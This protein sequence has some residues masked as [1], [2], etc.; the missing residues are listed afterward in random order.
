MWR[1]GE[2]KKPRNRKKQSEWERSKKMFFYLK[3]GDDQS[4]LFNSKCHLVVLLNFIR[5]QLQLPAHLTLDFMPLSNDVKQLIPLQLP[6][7]GDTTYANTLLGPRASYAL[8]SVTEDEDGAKEYTL[9]WKS[10]STRQED[11]DRIAAAIELRNGEEKKKAGGA[12]P[13]P[14]K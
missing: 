5:S 3:H 13:K 6:E 1:L 4:P 14:K 2:K 7:K 10:S 9:L 12:K 11:R 8:L